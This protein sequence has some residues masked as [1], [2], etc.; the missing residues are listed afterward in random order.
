MSSH[1]N[2]NMFYFSKAGFV[3]PTITGL[4]S[5]LSSLGTMWFILKSKSNTTYHRII[6]TLSFFDMITS[7]AI[8]MTTIPM[9]KDVI[10]PFAGSSFGTVGTCEAQGL[11]YTAGSGMVLF[12][13]GILNIYYVCSLRYGMKEEVFGKLIE[14]VLYLLALTINGVIPPIILLKTDLINPT[15]TDPFC[16]PGVYPIGCNNSNDPECRGGAEDN[17]NFTI[18]YLVAMIA[19]MVTLISSMCMIIH[20]FHKRETNIKKRFLRSRDEN[21]YADSYYGELESA[22]KMKRTLAKQA[23]MY[24]G[25]FLI[26]WLFPFISFIEGAETTSNWVQALRMVFQPLQGFFNLLI[27]FYHK[28]STVQKTDARRSFFDTLKIVLA[29]PSSV[30]EVLAIS[31]IQFVYAHEY[32]NKK[33]QENFMSYNIGDEENFEAEESTSVICKEDLVSSTS[34]S[35]QPS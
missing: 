12:M 20:S 21:R 30:P 9:P 35:I 4:I 8:A 11:I 1:V 33:P 19:G 32:L 24:V 25:A 6:F 29:T 17:R 26:T 2:E 23:M 13:N 10:Y 27:F 31:S 3:V 5:C 14:P 34:I 7:L 16:R 18:C 22:K 15:I 28:V